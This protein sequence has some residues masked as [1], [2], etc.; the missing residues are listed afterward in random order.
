MGN[1]IWYSAFPPIFLIA[2]NSGSNIVEEGF[3]DDGFWH[4]NINLGQKSLNL[5]ETLQLAEL[6]EHLLHISPVLNTEDNFI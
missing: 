3:W 5:E 6:Y 1:E 4:L 2:A